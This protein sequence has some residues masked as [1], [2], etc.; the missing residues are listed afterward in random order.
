MQILS[1]YDCNIFCR[2]DSI[3]VMYFGQVTRVDWRMAASK[4]TMERA[5]GVSRFVLLPGAETEQKLG[6][7]YDYQPDNPNQ[8]EI[9]LWRRVEN[10][11]SDLLDT[12]SSHPLVLDSDSG[13]GTATTD[14]KEKRRM[15]AK[16]RWE[17]QN[18]RQEMLE[19]K[20]ARM[21][22]VKQRPTRRDVETQ[23][24]ISWVHELSHKG[25]QSS[26]SHLGSLF[27]NEH[28]KNC[29]R[30]CPSYTDTFYDIAALL[31][32]SS[33][34]AYNVMRQVVILPARTSIYR[35]YSD[36]FHKT[37][38]RLLDLSQLHESLLEIKRL[39]SDLSRSG[40]NVNPICTLG[41]DAFCFRS[42]SGGTVGTQGKKSVIQ[43]LIEEMM[44]EREPSVVVTE[45]QVKYSYGFIFLLIPHDYRLPPKLVHLYAAETGSY[46]A[47]ITQ[48][49]K[50]IRALTKEYGLHI[51]CKAT[52]GDPGVSNEHNKFFVKH[53]DGKS[54]NFGQL[55]LH[56]N[57]WL[58]ASSK[59]WIPIADPLH[60][61]KNLRARLLSH[62]II[63]YSDC[64][65]T[66]LD[67]IRDALKLGNV[68]DDE[69]QIGKMRDSYVVSLF[70]FDNVSKLLKKALYVEA[71]LL[72]PF[73]CWS[74][75][76]FSEN[77]DL[78]LRL[79]LVELAFQVI[80]CWYVEGNELSI[81]SR[82][83]TKDATTFCDAQYARRM[84][85]TLAAFGVSLSFGC[86][87]MRMD[88][89]GTHLVENNIGIARA[90]SSDPR[91]ERI[92]QTFAHAQVRKEIAG[93]HGIQL[94]VQ[95]RV[96]DGGCKVDPDYQCVGQTLISKPSHWRV[97]TLLQLLR[98]ICQPETVEFLRGARDQFITDMET[99]IPS[100]DKHEY[101]INETANCGIMARIVSLR[102]KTSHGGDPSTI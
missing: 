92:I 100:L 19:K 36:T 59:R 54:G 7:L 48:T 56:L 55:V 35:H 57:M 17:K 28:M 24:K 78:G 67:K 71:C 82:A 49:A 89:L 98:G 37:A 65:A 10:V 12:L 60:V 80:H 62:P 34:K 90:S 38:Q 1:R 3:F 46:N 52:D 45:R 64:P 9:T 4:T 79:F 84:L 99:L 87:N 85:N 77:I 39:I 31:F 94:H 81:R 18:S 83:K 74:A 58:S 21:T 97:D 40:L 50:E 8:M 93:R 51:W 25:Y 27:L 29:S 2:S 88:A 33:P 43:Q 102:K 53:V 76:I 47:S 86:D 63:L 23:T 26:I 73:A 96:N 13:T 20:C 32:L 16:A 11:N 41:I 61:F 91:Y 72:F 6:V 66:S 44:E 68:L 70:T 30:A 42:F 5:M 101:S 14:L 75:V 69:S 15:A 95:G 22:E